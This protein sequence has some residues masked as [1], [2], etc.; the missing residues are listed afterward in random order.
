MQALM[1]CGCCSCYHRVE[2]LGDCREDSER[3]L[4]EEDFKE[5]TGE[6]A[7]AAITIEDQRRGFDE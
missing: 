1:E 4:D 6:W 3:F 2:F 7:Y 5:R